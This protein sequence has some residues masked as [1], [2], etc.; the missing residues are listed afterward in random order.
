MEYI[1][2]YTGVLPALGFP[3]DQLDAQFAI[4]DLGEQDPMGLLDYRQITCFEPARSL[5]GLEARTVQ[6]SPIDYQ[7]MEAACI[8]QVH[9]EYGLTGKGVLI[10]FVDSGLDPGHPEFRR[11]S[12]RGPFT[13]GSRSPPGRSP[14]GT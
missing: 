10:G 5:S 12:A 1:I 7:S 13:P 4:M 2:K 9:R 3:T 6:A 14:G 11:G 8:P